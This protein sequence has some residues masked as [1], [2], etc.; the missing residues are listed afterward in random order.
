MAFALLRGW[1]TNHRV[2]PK[3]RLFTRPHGGTLSVSRNNRCAKLHILF[4][5]HIT[6]K[7]WTPYV[8]YILT[9]LRLFNYT[10]PFKNLLKAK[11]EEGRRRGDEAR[12]KE[13][14]TKK[15]ERDETAGRAG[16]GKW[17]NGKWRMKELEMESERTG[18]GKRESENSLR[19][20]QETEDGRFGTRKAQDLPVWSTPKTTNNL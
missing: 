15:A 3:A 7:P 14:P 6:N 1:F 20:R 5:T 10:K 19:V 17:E 18:N 4:H 2:R 12:R 11:M 8:Y 16:N 13:L 9:V